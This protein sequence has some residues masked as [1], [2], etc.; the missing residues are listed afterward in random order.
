[1]PGAGRWLGAYA[2]AVSLGALVVSAFLA[3]WGLLGLQTWN[4]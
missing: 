2:V 3:S 1:M 4:W